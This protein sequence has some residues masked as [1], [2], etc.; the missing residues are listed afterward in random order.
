MSQLDFDRIRK[1]PA[2]DAVAS[3][4]REDIIL[5]VFKSGQQLQLRQ[6]AESLGVSATPVREA[7]QILE[8]E[9]LVRLTPNKGAE[10]IGFDKQSLHEHYEL[11]EML[12]SMAARKI[13]AN[14]EGIKALQTIYEE[15]KKVVKE[16][17]WDEY[18]EINRKFHEAI[19]VG[20]GNRPLARVLTGLW[21]GLSIGEQMSKEEYARQSLKEHEELLEA[22]ANGDGDKASSLMSEHITRSYHD[23]LTH[24]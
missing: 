11:R 20:S 7:L 1:Q 14:P 2:R 12:E 16:C 10:V 22:I 6:L 17:K 18:S 19:W 9:D 15:A 23:A 24:L 3:R 4:L 5:G 13:C 8:R 21:N